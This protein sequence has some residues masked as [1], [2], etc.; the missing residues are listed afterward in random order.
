MRVAHTFE[1]LPQAKV[2]SVVR[3]GNID[4]V[5]R[6]LVNGCP[7]PEPRT[8][9]QLQRRVGVMFLHLVSTALRLW[10]WVVPTSGGDVAD[11]WSQGSA[12]GGWSRS[13]GASSP[14][15]ATSSGQKSPVTRAYQRLSKSGHLNIFRLF[16]AWLKLLLNSCCIR[17]RRAAGK[18]GS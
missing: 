13:G 11:A 3:L 16:N 14:G 18:A 7:N 10:G 17:G 15:R 9:L 2:A 6:R 8:Y 12:G 4:P 5:C 1:V